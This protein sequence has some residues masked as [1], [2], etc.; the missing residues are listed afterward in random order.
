MIRRL[1]IALCALGTACSHA[2][3][4]EPPAPAPAPAAPQV[5]APETPK[6]D[7][8]EQVLAQQPSVPPL[9]P[10]NAPVPQVTRLP[11]GLELYVVER[12]GEGIEALQLISRHGALADPPKL[13]GL[14][15]MSAA[16]LE[17]GSAGKSQLEIARAIEDLGATMHA[18]GDFDALAV[19]ISALP[20]RLD[21]MVGLLADVALRPNLDAKEFTL[22]Q[23]KREAEL[24]ASKAEPRAAAGRAFGRAVYPGSPLGEPLTGTPDSVKAMKLKDVRRFLAG[25]VPGNTAIV[26]VGG[27]Q[28]SEV[29]AALTR[30]FGGWKGGKPAALPNVDKLPPPGPRFVLVDYPGKPQSVLRVGQASVPRKSPDYLALNLFNSVL[31]G[32][33][34]SRLNQNL[35]EQHGYTYGA[36]SA[37]GFG[38]GPGPFEV[39]TS[40]QTPA[41]G[42]SL[43]EIFKELHRA[44]AEPITAEELRKGKAL[45][46]FQ[47]VE[48]LQHAE[49]AA[50]AI[51]AIPIY[52][53]PTDEYRTFVPRLNALTVEG[54]TAAAQ[55]ALQ[56]TQ[57]TV[58][59]AGDAGQAIEQVGKTQGLSLPPPERLGPFGEPVK[60][61]RAT[62]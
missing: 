45:L 6:A 17:A 27:A 31:G 1:M 14:A 3:K 48:E 7:P 33:F 58:L 23:Q 12:E 10:F 25:V 5:S 41:T 40:V 61:E 9:A 26:A 35:R 37:F 56:P 28:A 50:Q 13:A 39:V 53:L 46:A 29:V 30:A 57:L 2:Q 24:L 16:M 52:G 20:S 21:G 44:T 19:T 34:T 15:S 43:S 60:A 38:I 11:N 55:R 49:G 8:A 42:A 51:G 32:S 54:V 62:K 4:T 47:L 36:F 22:L 59:I 18:S